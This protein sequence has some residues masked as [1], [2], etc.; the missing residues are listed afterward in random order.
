MRDNNQNTI[1]KEF[2]SIKTEEAQ[3]VYRVYVNGV[4]QNKTPE[5]IQLDLTNF[6]ITEYDLTTSVASS[7]SAR[8]YENFSSGIF[9]ESLIDD[10]VSTSINTEVEHSLP[11]IKISLED[12]QKFIEF[13]QAD[14]E[15]T[16]PLKK[17]L[18]SFI[19]FYRRNYHPSGW[20]KYDKKNIFYL[21]GANKMPITQQE[22][23][24]NYL[25]THYGL[26]MRVVGSNQPTPCY[27]MSWLQEQPPVGS[28]NNP[29]ITLGLLTPSDLTKIIEK[30]K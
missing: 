4:K 5:E 3:A 6:L 16:L 9:Q 23:M 27:T 8:I 22:K 12:Y 25:H 13:T 1:T 14:P 24:T 7:V 10:I 21:A 30:T 17:L 2:L 26:N 11:H 29:F 15:I 18:F 28:T 20:I 19:V